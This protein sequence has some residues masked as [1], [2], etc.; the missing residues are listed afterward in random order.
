M[1][2]CNIKVEHLSLKAW[3]EVPQNRVSMTAVCEHGNGRSRTTNA[4]N[5]LSHE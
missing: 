1:Q 4:G 5:F 2:R 3:I